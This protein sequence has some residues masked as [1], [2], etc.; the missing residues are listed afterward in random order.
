MKLI[1]IKELIS[2]SETENALKELIKYCSSKNEYSTFLN[3]LIILSGEF[4]KYTREVKWLGIK[5]DDSTFNKTNY[6]ILQIIDKLS[7]LNRDGKL[8]S[9]SLSVINASLDSSNHFSSNNGEI[10]L[11]DYKIRYDFP[12]ID[13]KLRNNSKKKIYL[14]KF[15]INIESYALNPNPELEFF[16][17]LQSEVFS[18]QKDIELDYSYRRFPNSYNHKDTYKQLAVK[19][20]NNGWGEAQECDIILEDSILNDNFSNNKFSWSGSIKSGETL[21]IA[22]FEYNKNQEYPDEK[23][24]LKNIGLN[25]T[26]YNEI[27]EKISRKRSAYF[28]ST[29]GKYYDSS[30][31]CYLTSNGIL[32]ES[33]DRGTREC[34]AESEAMYIA[35]INQNQVYKE[36]SISHIIN[37]EDFARFHV[38]IGTEKSCKAKISFSFEI[39]NGER[40]SSNPLSI[41]I[42]NPLNALYHKAY[43]DGSRLVK[44]DDLWILKGNKIDRRGRFNNFFLQ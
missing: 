10:T 18:K 3:D 19:V 34:Y 24:E 11:I 1:K 37:S 43:S 31:N 35:I 15:N 2:K 39:D 16:F 26:C 27:G 42:R 32:V 6:S 33:F 38:M 8:K 13:F 20:K 22:E 23:K 29:S 41:S 28:R 5:E 7:T 36:Y 25:Y 14:H 12:V 17:E 40:I 21:S 4:E 9:N 30:I 44:K